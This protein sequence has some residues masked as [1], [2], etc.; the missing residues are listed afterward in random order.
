[1]ADEERTAFHRTVE[2]RSAADDGAIAR[3]SVTLAS[4]LLRCRGFPVEWLV[5]RGR[6]V[7]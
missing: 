3:A 2:H 5:E 6:Q 7:S 1:M 4:E